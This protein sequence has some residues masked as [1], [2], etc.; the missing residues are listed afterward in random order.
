MPLEPGRAC[1][2][3]CPSIVTRDQPC[4]LHSRPTGPWQRRP[5]NDGAR[6]RGRAGMKLR[7][8][9]LAEEP[10]CAICNGWGRGDDE[11]DHIDGDKRN[12]DRLNLRRV[13]KLCHHPKTHAESMRWRR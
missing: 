8:Q 4:P 12:N 9:V 7:Y 1:V 3:G 11:V 10:R 6:L 13:H 2:Y 5:K